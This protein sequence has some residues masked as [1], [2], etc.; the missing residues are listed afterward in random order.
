MIMINSYVCTFV[1]QANIS[2][3]GFCRVSFI[4]FDCKKYIEKMFFN[5]V[6][7]YKKKV[8]WWF[9]SFC[10]LGKEGINDWDF[11]DKQTSGG[12]VLPSLDMFF[13]KGVS[14]VSFQF[15]PYSMMVILVP[16]EKADEN[17]GR[18][19]RE[20]LRNREE[21]KLLPFPLLFIRPPSKQET[22]CRNRLG[23]S[24]VVKHEKTEW[25]K[26]EKRPFFESQK[27]PFSIL[28]SW[29]LERETSVCPRTRGN[30]VVVINTLAA[31][32]KVGFWALFYAVC[33]IQSLLAFLPSY[34][35]PEWNLSSQFHSRHVLNPN[36]VCKSYLYL[37]KNL[38]I[39]GNCWM[40][41][42]HAPK[43]TNGIIMTLRLVFKRKNEEGRKRKISIFRQPPPLLPFRLSF[44]REGCRGWKYSGVF[45]AKWLR[46]DIDCRRTYEGGR[47]GFV[48]S[49]LPF[50]IE[51]S[52]VQESV[53]HKTDHCLSAVVLAS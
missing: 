36:C 30:S 40:S 38:K 47:K 50:R 28:R 27:K 21:S 18:G 48:Y 15:T 3:F 43:A 53:L 26:E 37:F 32:S 39:K 6:L 34:D 13:G 51:I 10:A 16:F 29:S 5:T 2:I 23:Q 12:K 7:L 9:W 41:L 11:C 24:S 49:F 20:I 17:G 45:S 44:G 46:C 14:F 22:E 42:Y 25:R 31:T 4:L 33:R 19:E 35:S 1:C 52:F 8:I